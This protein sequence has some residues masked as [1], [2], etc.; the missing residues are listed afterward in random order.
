M[1]L[2]FCCPLCKGALDFDGKSYSCPSC[3]KKYPVVLGIADF[4]VFPDPYISIEAD[5]K[6]G[7]WLAQQA[8][9]L[10]FQELVRLY[11]KITP[12]VSEDRAEH[13]MRHVFTLV[14]KGAERLKEIERLDRHEGRFHSI[15]ELGC[16]TGG[17]LVAAKDRFQDVIGIDI[18]FRWLVIAKKRLN[19]LGVSLPLVCGCAESLPFKDGSYD[20]IAADNVLAHVKDQEAALRECRRVLNNDGVL[21]LTTPN[22][23]SIRSEPH[24]GVWGVGFLPRFLTD[25][26]VYWKKGI[27]YR[28]IRLPSRFELKR[29]LSESAFRSWSISPPRITES[30]QARASRF[31]QNLIRLYHW[32]RQLP[33]FSFLFQIFGPF[34]QII[35]RK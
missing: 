22:R 34:L 1:P 32:L 27:R 30:E 15:L 25:R 13:F 29:M 11:W 21:F 5:H 17:F 26:Y 3:I 6:K 8:D 35:G 10:N 2:S 14:E 19:E 20:V 12:E 28:H 23:F 7:Q 33:V 9:R 24:V 18:A 16:G 31:E 4:R